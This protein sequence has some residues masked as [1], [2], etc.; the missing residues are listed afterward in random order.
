[1]MIGSAA[2]QD[3]SQCR[4]FMDDVREHAHIMN[5]TTCANESHFD[6]LIRFVS[7]YVCLVEHM[8]A[9]IGNIT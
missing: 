4:R 5:E 1:M 2:A 8:V 6:S 3:T 9:I 7:V